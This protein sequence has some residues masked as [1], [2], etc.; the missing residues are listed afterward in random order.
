MYATTSRQNLLRRFSQE[1]TVIEELTAYTR[2]RFTFSE[3]D[4]QTFF[5]LPD[6][7]QTRRWTYYVEAAHQIGVYPLLKRYISPFQFP[8]QKGISQWSPYRSVTLKGKSAQDIP[9]ATGLVLQSPETLEIKMYKSIV[10][11]IP[12]LIV[13]H[14]QDFKTIIQALAHKNEPKSIPASMGASIIKGLNNWD[15]IQQ[16]KKIWKIA[17]PGGRWATYFKQSI[18]PKKNLYQ[19][20]LIVLSTKPYSGLSAKKVGLSEEEWLRHSMD[21]R[22]EHECAHYF[23]LRHLGGMHVNMHDELIADYMGITQVLGHFRADWFLAFIGLS[24]KGY[25]PGSRLENYVGKSGLSDSAFLILQDILRAAIEQVATFNCAIQSTNTLPER[26]AQ[27]LSL[28]ALT[29]EEMAVSDGERR[30]VEKYESFLKMA[31]TYAS[32]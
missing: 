29:L 10:G 6:E 19:D 17:N 14:E 3:L 28:S 18:L 5:S 27:L 12:V 4:Q 7:P 31:E 8:I 2:N 25:Q 1:E 13:S 24:D 32:I 11:S 16:L 26:I 20:T 15:R 21:L 23:T 30:L 9:E 22:L